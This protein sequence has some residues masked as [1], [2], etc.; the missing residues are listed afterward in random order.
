MKKKIK[1][2]DEKDNI[3]DGDN[4]KFCIHEKY[5]RLRGDLF[6]FFIVIVGSLIYSVGM[7]WFV[8][9]LK[10]YAGGVNGLAQLIV[11]SLD[12]L[13]GFKGISVGIMLFLIN[14]PIVIFAWKDMSK[15]FGIFSVISILVQT[16]FLSGIIPYV[17]F[18]ISNDHF[19]SSIV[20]GIIMGFGGA[21]TLRYGTSTG[22][23]D[24][25]GQ[26]LAI[27]KNVSIGFISLIFNI[28]IAIL[29]GAV[30]LH[31]WEITMYTIVRIIATSI[32]YDVVHTSYNYVRIDI[33]STNDDVYAIAQM[34]NKEF[35]RGCTILQGEGAYSR[36]PRQV[37]FI[38]VS[39]FE[40]QKI[41][42]RVKEMD[43]SVFITISPVRRVIGNFTRK[44]IA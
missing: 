13:V 24:I 23:L 4:K 36:K 10:L 44:N 41:I 42:R 21:L 25:I 33:I 30:L 34:I 19:M 12:E 15:R 39:S 38:V 3:N 9:P 40:H 7:L 11:Y 14:V 28:A 31:N 1:T 43:K 27:K 5:P 18:G 20:G 17:D 6:R 32:V 2:I 35:N 16:V 22:G 26:V 37:L 29:G 8:E